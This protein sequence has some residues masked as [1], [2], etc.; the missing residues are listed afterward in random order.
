MADYESRLS[1]DLQK[2]IKSQMRKLTTTKKLENYVMMWIETESTGKS[3]SGV[4]A[5]P[6]G[7][8]NTLSAVAGSPSAPSAQPGAY[9][10]KAQS[11]FSTDEQG[12]IQA[13]Q[14]QA[15]QRSASTGQRPRLTN[16]SGGS[17]MGQLVLNV[18][19]ITQI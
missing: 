16:A 11:Y 13:M 12:G 10:H 5:V 15:A 9:T 18:A 6:A 4:N 3:Q 1:V 19:D 8:V 7:T 2:F 14:R 17:H